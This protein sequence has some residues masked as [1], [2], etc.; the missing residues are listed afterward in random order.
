[1]STKQPPTSSSSALSAS[2]DEYM[3]L[4][5]ELAAKRA[6]VDTVRLQARQLISKRDGVST[7]TFIQIFSICIVYCYLLIQYVLANQT[8]QIAS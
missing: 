2:G 7:I 6:S 1:M 4:K 5:L 3:R 8:N